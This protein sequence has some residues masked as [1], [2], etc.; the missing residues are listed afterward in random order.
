MFKAMIARMLAAVARRYAARRPPDLIIGTVDNPY[1]HR[2]WVIPRNEVC[3]IYLHLFLRDDDDRALHDHPWDNASLVLASG[4]NEVVP[5]DATQPAGQTRSIERKLGD[6]IRRT[7]EDA[8]RV[9]L[10]RDEHGRPIPAWSLFMTGK[11]RRTWGFWCPK[12]WRHYKK[13]VE[14]KIDSEGRGVSSVGRGCDD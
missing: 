5:V 3:N 10:R 11:L 2:W 6:L 4:Y 1:V 13:F 9:V 14:L 8:H 12:G 7:A